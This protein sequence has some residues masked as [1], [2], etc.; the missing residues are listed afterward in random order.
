MLP[1]WG[2]MLLGQHPWRRGPVLWRTWVPARL[3]VSSWDQ[4]SIH[5]Q[6][7]LQCTRMCFHVG[8]SWLPSA[9]Q[10]S[11]S[12]IGEKGITLE[13]I[14]LQLNMYTAPALLAAA[15]G[16]VNILLVLLVLRWGRCMFFKAVW[17]ELHRYEHKSLVQCLRR[18]RRMSVC[19]CLQQRAPRRWPRTSYSIHQR[20]LRRYKCL[21]R[22]F[23]REFIMSADLWV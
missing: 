6:T 9:L 20:D 7:R 1:W 5:P 4:V 12:V 21:T 15:F 13:V 19:D 2:L 10:A 14:D 11:L 3:W 18:R 23:S 16:V 22:L 17:M 8:L